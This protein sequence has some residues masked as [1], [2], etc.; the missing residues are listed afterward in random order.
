MTEQGFVVRTNELVSRHTAL[1]TGGPCAAFVTAHDAAGLID[2]RAHCRE[3]GWSVQLIGAGTRTVA[4]DGGLEAALM[5]LGEGFSYARVEDNAFCVGAAFPVPALVSYALGLGYGGL[6]HAAGICG[7][8]GASLALDPGWDEVVQS[9]TV[10]RRGRLVSVSLA[11]A[12]E[13][14]RCCIVSAILDLP[15]AMLGEEEAVRRVWARGECLSAGSWYA[16]PDGDAPRKVFSNVVLQQVR[17]RK[18]MIPASAPEMLV[19][20]GGGT[21]EDLRLLGRST[22]DR[23]KRVRGVALRESYRWLGTSTRKGR[24]NAR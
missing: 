11:E 13:I 22:M 20:L 24:T 19:N 10:V 18:V 12:R 21:A 16:S 15:V 8:V 2:G 23:V 3:Q 14:K 1:R 17:L 7:S 9:V 4:R 5:R 6:L